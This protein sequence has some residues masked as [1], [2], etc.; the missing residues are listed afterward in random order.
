[1]GVYGDGFES[2]HELI[3]QQLDAPDSGLQ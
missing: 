1:M 2:M 3:A